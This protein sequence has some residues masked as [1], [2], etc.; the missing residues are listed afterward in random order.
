[1]KGLM[2]SGPPKLGGISA[3]HLRDEPGIHQDVAVRVQSQPVMEKGWTEGKG[4]LPGWARQVGGRQRAEGC[5]FSV[6][7]P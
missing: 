2:L 1:M 6:P 7:A 5:R 3:E 4:S